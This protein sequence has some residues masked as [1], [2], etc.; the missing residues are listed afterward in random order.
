MISNSTSVKITTIEIKLDK[1]FF[2]EI[3]IELNITIPLILTVA[4]KNINLAPETF[5]LLLGFNQIKKYSSVFYCYFYIFFSSLKNFISSIIK[6]PLSA[7][8]YIIIRILK[9]HKEFEPDYKRK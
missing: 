5:I 7:V 6:F 1:Y 4:L 2:P 9:N 8:Y 3:N